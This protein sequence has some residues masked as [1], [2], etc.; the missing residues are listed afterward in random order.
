MLESP[1]LHRLDDR[2]RA[3]YLRWVIGESTSRATL[4]FWTLLTHMGGTTASA[5]FALVPLFMAEGEFRVPA[6]QA[7]WTLSISLL[8]VQGIKR[9]VVRTRPTER[10]A[11]SAHIAVPDRFSFPSGHSAAAMSVA[12]IYAATFHSLG[13]PLLVV[14]VLIGVSRVR[15]G[16]HYPGD[17]LVGQLIAIGTGVVVRALW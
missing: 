12:F 9:L 11:S 15:L 3:L 4:F 13:W 5:A 10:V 8:V 1:L 7:A 16:A 6:I 2:D 17:V 14:A